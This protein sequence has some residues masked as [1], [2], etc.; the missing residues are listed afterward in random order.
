MEIKNNHNMRINI[1][2]N[3]EYYEYA[4]DKCYFTKYD[5]DKFIKYIDYYKQKDEDVKQSDEYKKYYEELCD[6]SNDT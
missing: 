3:L 2:R 1:I 6:N 4:I 5:Y